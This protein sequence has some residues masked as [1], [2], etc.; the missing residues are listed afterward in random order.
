MTEHNAG[1]FI[2]LQEVLHTQLVDIMAHLNGIDADTADAPAQGPHWSYVGVGRD[3]GV[4]AGEYSPII[5]PS[6]I[7]TVLESRTVWL[8]ETPSKPGRGW[9]A[10]SIRILNLC[11]FE[12]KA[13]HR[14][15]LAANTH[16]DDQGGISRV[17]SVKLILR[18]L[19]RWHKE[20]SQH[21]K[22]DMGVLLAGDFN[23]KPDDAA[24]ELMKDSKVMVDAYSAIEPSRRYGH[25][26]TF[27][28]FEPEKGAGDIGR[29]DFVWLRSGHSEQ[30]DFINQSWAVAGYA[31]LPNV[32]D[33][34]VYLSDHRAV[35]VD[36]FAA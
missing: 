4:T 12:H 19:A 34:G 35:V 21:A 18:V 33:N 10:A 32:F 30:Q 9:D 29:I 7:F 23:S 28:G 13:T 25:E 2:C 6:S 11:V 36:L 14:L 20:W 1:A 3:D 15:V 5:Y 8:S 16:L 24:Y 31:V 27:T 17:E 26:V 22:Q